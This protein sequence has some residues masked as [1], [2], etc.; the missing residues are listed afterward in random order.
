[1]SCL[2][3][4]IIVYNF[5]AFHPEPSHTENPVDKEQTE[6][7]EQP[8]GEQ[9]LRRGIIWSNSSHKKEDQEAKHADAVDGCRGP[10]VDLASFDVVLLYQSPK[11]SHAEDQAWDG[12]NPI[13][14]W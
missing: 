5:A 6:S 3:E 8:E 10:K 9:I 12:S 11:P 14:A 7:E 1:M 4:V 13:S 2:L